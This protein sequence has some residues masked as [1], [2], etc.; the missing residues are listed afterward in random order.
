[1]RL[2]LCPITDRDEPQAG[3]RAAFSRL[4]GCEVR[5]YLWRDRFMGVGVDK[6]WK[7]LKVQQQEFQPDVVFFQQIHVLTGVM[8]DE[9]RGI[10]PSF[11]VHWSGD[12]RKRP[13][14]YMIE[15]GQAVDLTLITNRGELDWYRRLG[16]RNIDYW[17]IAVDP[18]IFHLRLPDP[19]F[20]YEVVYFGNNYTAGEPVDW[21]GVRWRQIIL[22]ELDKC[23]DLT[24]FGSGWS[25]PL[26]IGPPYLHEEAALVYSSSKV[27]IGIS[28]FNGVHSYTSDRL[29]RMLA[30]GICCV[31]A[32]FPGIEEIAVDRRHLAW[33][34]TTEE[35]V[36][37]VGYY[38][39]H[40]DERKRMATE[41]ARLAHRSHVWPVRVHEFLEV[42]NKWRSS[43]SSG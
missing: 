35:C 3:L 37:L 14:E 29:F 25:G 42:I 1:M 6:M 24:V 32:W 23:F 21:P 12:I 34:K 33:F 17:Q 27:G 7:E 36:A 15:L 43:I 4:D 8:I 26:K 5:E 40:A 18:G 10:H 30:S 41:G 31:C 9:L 20:A 39:K 11:F 38:L 13:Q 19:E 28:A 2:L 16:V 22:G